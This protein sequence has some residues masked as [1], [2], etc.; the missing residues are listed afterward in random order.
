MTTPTEWVTPPDH[1]GYRVKVIQRGP[2]TIEI[3]RPI[4]DAE[5]QKKREAHLKAV[6]ERTLRSYYNR[7][8]HT[9]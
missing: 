5:E 1:P 3:L 2:C 4:L 9:S 7:K 8:E 6:A